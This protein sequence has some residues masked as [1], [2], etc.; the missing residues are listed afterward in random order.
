MTK[1]ITLYA[2]FLHIT[3][4]PNNAAMGKEAF[5]NTLT[6]LQRGVTADTA[7]SVE[8]YTGEKVSKTDYDYNTDTVYYSENDCTV[9][10]E[11]YKGEPDIFMVKWT[12]A[13]KPAGGVYAAKVTCGSGEATF[14]KLLYKGAGTQE[15]PYLINDATDF[16]AINTANIPQ[17]NYYKLLQSVVVR[18]ASSKVAGYTFDGNLDGN[19]KTVTIEAS[20]CGLFA[21]LGKN[22][23]IYDLSVNGSI[24]GVTENSAGVIAAVNNGNISYCNVSATL[25]SEPRL[26]KVK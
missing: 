24:P 6:W 3:A 26:I 2:K 25:T 9:T 8:L 15:N 4:A 18:A 16:A 13:V 22:A 7:Y 10:V 5:S 12:A 17:G 14:G 11:N 21:T 23:L 1:D 19:G 20:D